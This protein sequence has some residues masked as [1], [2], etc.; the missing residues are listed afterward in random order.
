M[1]AFSWPTV[2]LYF[3]A[4]TLALLIPFTLLKSSTL[5]KGRA[6]MISGIKWRLSLGHCMAN[7][8]SLRAAVV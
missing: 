3:R 4:S 7:N 8:I 6:A 1:A 5:L 2:T